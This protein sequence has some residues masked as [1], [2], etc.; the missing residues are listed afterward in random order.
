MKYLILGSSGQIG[1]HLVNFLKNKNYEVIE[2]DIL[3]SEQQDLRINNNE[4]LDKEVQSCDFIYFLAFDVGGSRYLK[5]Y[6]NTF[7]FINNNIKIMNVVFNCIKKYNKPFLFASSQMSAME[8]SS[9]GTLKRIG[10]FYTKALEGLIV[11]FWNVY[12]IEKDLEKSHA[13]T[14]FILKA[15]N[16]KKID[17]LTDGTEERQFLYAEDCC[18]CLLKLSSIYKQLDRK[19]EYHISSFEWVSIL[20]VA[21]TIK[22]LI[23]CDIFPNKEKDEVQKNLK[24]DPNKNI[25]KFWKPKTSLKDGIT[26]VVEHYKNV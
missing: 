24:N 26:K 18:E 19:E 10:E 14:D 22:E 9:Y 15:L 12:G 23:P 2:F 21:E 6:Q 13:I 11:R 7:E 25:L 3:N 5:Q 8:Y 16:N 1:Q 4:L 17:M 20:S